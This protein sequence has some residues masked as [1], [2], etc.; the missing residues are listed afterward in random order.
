MVFLF[1]IIG[2]IIGLVTVF[3]KGSSGKEI[4]AG[5]LVIPELIRDFVEL[6]IGQI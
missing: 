1:K 6:L 2:F 4:A 5:F 3:E